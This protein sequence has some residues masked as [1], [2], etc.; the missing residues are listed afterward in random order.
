MTL[1]DIRSLV[2]SYLMRELQNKQYAGQITTMTNKEID[3][4]INTASKQLLSETELLLASETV[5][6]TDGVGTVTGKLIKLVRVEVADSKIGWLYKQ[7]IREAWPI[8][9][10]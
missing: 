4:A 3:A 6:L 2:R 7:S 9:G 8:G 10:V 1:R 5:T